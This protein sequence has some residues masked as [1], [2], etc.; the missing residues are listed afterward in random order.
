MQAG[1]R[2]SDL[3]EKRR[4]KMKCDAP[5]AG[6]VVVSALEARPGISRQERTGT[7]QGSAVGGA[8]LERTLN[9]GGNRDIAVLFL[10]WPVL[11]PETTDEFADAPSLASP[12]NA[13]S[14]RPRGSLGKTLSILKFHRGSVTIFLENDNHLAG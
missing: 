13:R 4:R 2:A 1:Y 11:W 9:D 6:A 14:R 10:E 7:E 5:I 8:T 12:D 3:L